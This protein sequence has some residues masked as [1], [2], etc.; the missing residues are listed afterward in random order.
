METLI[1]FMG[2]ESEFERRL[3]YIFQPGTSEQDLGA[4]GASITTLMNIGNEPDFA[5]PYEYH[6]INKQHKSVNQTRALANEFFKNANYGVP[7][8]SDAGAL[9]S[10]LIWQMIGLYPVVTQPVY[11]IN[12]PWFE[13]IN[14]T[15]NGN[16]TL[17]ITATNL[18]NA[19]SYFV[20]SVKVNGRDWD[21]NWLEHSDIMVNGGTIEFEL[22]SETKR[23]ESGDVPPSPGHHVLS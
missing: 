19:N 1:Q 12:S 10:W 5:T 6:Y 7:G 14:M 13:D 16:S 11:L 21:K 9:N 3:D 8:N 4:N 17:R 20:Q 22:G 23:W 18:D 15:I 2:G